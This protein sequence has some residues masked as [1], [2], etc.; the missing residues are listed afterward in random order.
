MKK[1]I[2]LLILSASNIFGQELIIDKNNIKFDHNLHT[3][4]YQCK[5]SS[6]IF[7]EGLSRIRFIDN[8]T[9]YIENESNTG[10]T[11]IHISF[12]IDQ[13]LKICEVDYYTWDDLED[14]SS[15]EFYIQ[16]FK[17]TLNKNPFTDSIN[18]LKGFYDLKI[19][20]VYNPGEILSKENVK[21]KTK[22]FNYKASFDC[23]NYG[24]TKF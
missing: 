3:N 2:F 6:N 4:F 18:N 21:E 11:G 16:Q 23:S 24:K 5:E 7:E 8:Q 19:K 12:K 20:S 9:F 22:N 10:Y 14:G 15:T 13:Q 17:L 1:I